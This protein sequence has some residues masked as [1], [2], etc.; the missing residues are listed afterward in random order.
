[1]SHC[2][3]EIVISGSGE[4]SLRSPLCGVQW[5]TAQSDRGG[6]SGMTHD[7]RAFELQFAETEIAALA[8]RYGYAEDSVALRAGESIRSG[9]CSRENLS[10]IFQWKTKGR[11]I[12]RLTRNTDHEIQ[13]ALHLAVSAETER[14]AISVL[15]GLFGVDVPV[16]SAVLTAINP[17]RYT[18]IDYRALEALGQKTSNRSVDYYLAYLAAC[19]HLAAK[20]R[21][22]LRN[23]DRALW[24]WSLENSTSVVES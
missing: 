18:V 17:E 6:V 15:T 8:E 23:L 1:M 10:H 7:S 3:F 22:T 13:D 5:M 2:V 4:A 24:Q 9:H 20:H 14:A 19:R 21:V 11:G 12:S 16:A